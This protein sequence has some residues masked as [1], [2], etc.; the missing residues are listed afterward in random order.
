MKNDCSDTQ[1]QRPSLFSVFRGFLL[2]KYKNQAPD[3]KALQAPQPVPT[4]QDPIPTN[5][6]PALSNQQYI[7]GTCTATTGLHRPHSQAPASVQC[8]AAPL[9]R[10]CRAPTQSRPAHYP[11]CCLDL[12]H[13]VHL[14]ETHRHKNRDLQGRPAPPRCCPWHLAG[15]VLSA[16]SSLPTPSPKCGNHTAQLAC[17]QAAGT[18]TPA[19]D[20]T[21]FS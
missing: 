2:P 13:T 19:Q 1:I 16:R 9:F 14:T 17:L 12:E 11:T 21:L 7:P 4:D 18:N 5:F 3:L 6:L 20:F 10:A 15:C 8:P